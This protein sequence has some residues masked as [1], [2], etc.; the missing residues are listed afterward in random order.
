[1]HAADV[2]YA[3]LSMLP[4]VRRLLAVLETEVRCSRAGTM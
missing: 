2:D 1:M 4:T 3:V